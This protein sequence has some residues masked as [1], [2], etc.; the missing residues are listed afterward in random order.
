MKLVDKREKI[1]TISKMFNITREAIYQWIRRRKKY[2]NID[3]KSGYQKG[4]R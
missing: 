3:P 1:T 4:H 2:G